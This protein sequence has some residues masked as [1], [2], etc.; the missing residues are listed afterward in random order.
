LQRIRR[1]AGSAIVSVETPLADAEPRSGRHPT[2]PAPPVGVQ[3][4][5]VDERGLP[6]FSFSVVVTLGAG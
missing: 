6:Q 1:Q 4:D 2:A 5:R 3:P